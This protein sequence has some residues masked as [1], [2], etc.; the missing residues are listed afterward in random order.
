MR[1]ARVLPRYFASPTV[2]RKW[3]LHYL[4][5]A[6][7]YLSKYTCCHRFSVNHLQI[8]V[9]QLSCADSSASSAPHVSNSQ[10]NNSRTLRRS[11][12]PRIHIRHNGTKGRSASPGTD[13]SCKIVGTAADINS[14]YWCWEGYRIV[15]AGVGDVG[16][17]PMS[18]SVNRSAPY[19]NH[20][21]WS[22]D[23]IHKR[24]L[25]KVKF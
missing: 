19:T 7:G 24:G 13:H 6:W 25:N 14:H 4:G 1:Q 21:F 8:N 22:R 16:C 17:P 15:R 18:R 10:H 20:I 2:F 11:L 12:I 9:P 23:K 5:T 3:C